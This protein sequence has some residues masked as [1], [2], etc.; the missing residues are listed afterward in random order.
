MGSAKAT[1][2]GQKARSGSYTTDTAEYCGVITN[3]GESTKYYN[4]CLKFTTPKFSGRSASLSVTMN[5]MENSPKASTI[6]LRW[7]LCS[8]D[9]NFAN[10][11]SKEDVTDSKQ[12]VTGTASF[13]VESSYK[14]CSAFTIS[15][16]SL[17]S[18]TT[19]YL[20]IYSKKGVTSQNSL[21]FNQATK[22][23]ITVKYYD[24][25]LVYIDN[26]SGFDAYEI[27]IDNGSSWDAYEAYID[28]GSKF[29]L[30][31]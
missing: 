28:N 14:N 19:Y 4:F 6:P 13:A 12:I 7:A 27:Y 3:T 20:I 26:G 24:A 15:T 30:Y 5:A 1:I 25:G 10:Y 21:V 23:S 8:S 18:E 17:K 16:D 2:V 11:Q 31:S 9:T 29:E 22:H